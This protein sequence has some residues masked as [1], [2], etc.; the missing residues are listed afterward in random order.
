MLPESQKPKIKNY[1]SCKDI[2]VK[3]QNENIDLE[4]WRRVLF[5]AGSKLCLGGGGWTWLHANHRKYGFAAQISKHLF[6]NLQVTLQKLHSCFS[7]VCV[8]REI[9]RILHGEHDSMLAPYLFSCKLVW[10]I[11]HSHIKT[12]IKCS[13]QDAQN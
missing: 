5:K 10:N 3:P 4:T 1:K 6:R 9:N 12:D 2:P 8:S 13:W 7:T 11:D